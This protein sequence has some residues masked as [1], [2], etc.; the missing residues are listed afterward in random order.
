VPETPAPLSSRDR[1][2]LKARAQALE[3]ALQVGKAGVTDA[4][5]AEIEARL[6]REDLVKIRLLKS[7]T[8]EADRHAVA[9][10]LAA[11]AG[12]QLVEVRGNTV[13]LYRR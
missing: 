4:L 10:D 5:V 2:A 13:V 3:P 6:D 8:E 11:R 9:E 12:A 1:A 7:A